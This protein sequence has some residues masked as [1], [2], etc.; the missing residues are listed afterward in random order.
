MSISRQKLYA[1]GETFGESA[2]RLKPGG[3][4][5]GGGGGQAPPSTST[6]SNTIDTRFNP[7]ID[8]AT[9]TAGRVNGSGFTPYSGQRFADMT[10]TQQAGISMIQDR[11]VGGDATVKSGANYLQNQLNGGDRSASVNPYASQQNPYLDSMVQKA[12]G[13]V[14]G[15][16][17]A[18]QARSGSFGNSGIAEQ[19]AQQMGKIATDMYGQAYNTQA[20]LAE[21]QAGRNDSVY[22]QSQGNKMGAANMALQYGNQG[23]NDASQLMKA[24]G[25]MQDQEQQARDF[26]FNQFAEQQNLP[27]KQMSAYGGL[28][29]SSNSTGSS[30][31]TNSG[32]AKGGK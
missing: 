3:R 15:N 11:A 20:N 30:T 12:Q 2:T 5:Y 22:Q 26:D 32:G 25:Q 16:M 14:M 8:Y 23:Y 28:L 4:I 19:G 24:G 7:L 13:S 31:T 21:S 10:G 17:G 29:G 9:Q 18:L 1:F 27:Y 6:T